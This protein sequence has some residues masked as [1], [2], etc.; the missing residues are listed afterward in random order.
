MT[1]LKLSDLLSKAPKN[2]TV[3]LEGALLDE[4][5]DAFEDG[6]VFSSK[7]ALSVVKKYMDTQRVDY[8]DPFYDFKMMGQVSE[9]SQQTT[10][11]KLMAK[12]SNKD[13]FSTNGIK[14]TLISRN[15]N[16]G[17]KYRFIPN[18]RESKENS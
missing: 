7:N 1:K 3:G 17:N 15:I 2:S 5:I 12:L 18:F 4:L 6:R 16:N 14:Y 8:L 13:V 10:L 11:G 9:R